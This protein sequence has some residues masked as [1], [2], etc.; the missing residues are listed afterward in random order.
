MTAC[1]VEEPA[2]PKALGAD[3]DEHGCIG[4]AGYQWCART[5]QC[6]RPWELAEKQTFD[7][8]AK[9]FAQYCGNEP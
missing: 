2:A 9:A 5:K 1:G 7:N 6:E 3:R 8:T 4:S